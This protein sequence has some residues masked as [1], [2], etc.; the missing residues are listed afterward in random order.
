MNEL[1]DLHEK[2]KDYLSI[3]ASEQRI[4]DIIKQESRE[5]AD[6]FGDERR[7]EIS[8]FTGDVEDED[9][10]PVE[11]CILTLTEKGYMKRQ[12]VDT[13]KAQNRG[14]KGIMG[15]SRR[16]EDYAK[17]CLHAPHTT[18]CLFSPIR[19]RFS[20]LKATKFPRLQE[21]ARA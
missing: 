21:Q 13:Y 11:D 17:L 16:E 14:G 9:L 4:C 5:I 8:A 12:T 10:I 1:N 2:I 18:E 20:K 7:T 6:K 15:M 19:A 3:L